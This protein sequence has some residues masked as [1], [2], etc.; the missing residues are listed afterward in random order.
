V[1]FLKERR[2]EEM[3][4]NQTEWRHGRAAHLAA[5][6]ATRLPVV[7]KGRRAHGREVEGFTGGHWTVKVLLATEMTLVQ[8]RAG[9]G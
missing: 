2:N 5:G 1:L 8:A 9:S 6:M 7:F 3:Q 4:P